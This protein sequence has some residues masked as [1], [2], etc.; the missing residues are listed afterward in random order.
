M[1]YCQASELEF[2]SKF[3]KVQMSYFE[4]SNDAW[5]RM[6]FFDLISKEGDYNETF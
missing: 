4:L 2:P 5:L 1:I 3:M 6:N